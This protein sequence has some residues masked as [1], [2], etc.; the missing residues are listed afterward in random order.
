M[1]LDEITQYINEESIRGEI[2]RELSGIISDY[3]AG[4]I[5]LDDKNSLIEGV[6]EAF[7]VSE[8]ASDEVTVRWL[9]AIASVAVQFV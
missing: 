6:V 7:K 8:N 3:Q 4:T 9:V 5:S 1:N 2:A